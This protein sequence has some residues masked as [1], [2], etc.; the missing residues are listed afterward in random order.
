MASRYCPSFLFSSLW[1]AK[2]LPPSNYIASQASHLLWFN[3]IVV[4]PNVS[5]WCV[6]SN[7]SHWWQFPLWLGEKMAFEMVPSRW[8]CRKGGSSR[9][10]TGEEEGRAWSTVSL[11]LDGRKGAKS[12]IM[13]KELQFFLKLSGD[14]ENKNDIQLTNEWSLT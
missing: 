14:R 12:Q 5:T 11:I 13:R 8:C 1:D 2:I 10:R 3:Y 4:Q 6:F 9:R 7:H